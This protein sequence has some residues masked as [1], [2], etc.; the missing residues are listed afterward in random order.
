MLALKLE[1][2]AAAAAVGLRVPGRP[3]QTKVI[4]IL[5]AAS[6]SM[7]FKACLR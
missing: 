4:G 2:A 7:I 5:F 3:L 6:S 1:L